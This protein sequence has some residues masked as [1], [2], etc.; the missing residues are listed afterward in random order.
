MSSNAVVDSLNALFQNELLVIHQYMLDAA[1]FKHWGY[2]KLSVD[3][4]KEVEEEKGHACTVLDRILLIG[5]KPKF[6]EIKD[7]TLHNDFED[8]IKHHLE[9]ERCAVA[10]FK[11]GIDIANEHRDFVTVEMLTALLVEE[12]AHYYHVIQQMGII[13]RIGVDKYLQKSVTVG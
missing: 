13:K 1:R 2:Q 3:M 5:G 7:I 10:M 8:I 6:S 11:E 12:D 4:E 9:L